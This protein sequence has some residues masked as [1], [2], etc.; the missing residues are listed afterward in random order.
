MNNKINSVG[1][2]KLA[3]TAGEYKVAQRSYDEIAK[4]LEQK[5]K[6]IAKDLP[7]GDQLETTIIPTGYVLKT[8]YIPGPNAPKDSPKLNLVSSTIHG[9]SAIEDVAELA[10]ALKNQSKKTNFDLKGFIKG[11]P[12]MIGSNLSRLYLK[13]GKYSS[14]VKYD[15]KANEYTI[16]W[17]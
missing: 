3:F 8:R 9:D 17:K 1:T 6:L 11:L 10:E 13:L 7:D 2:N 14:E 5:I 4:V 12:I 15:N 16:N